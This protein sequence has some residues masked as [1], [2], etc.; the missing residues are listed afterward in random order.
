MSDI[1]G[2]IA[3]GIMAAGSLDIAHKRVRGLWM[4]LLG[5]FGWGYAGYL[6]GLYSLI[7]VSV[8]MGILDVYAIYHWSKD[9]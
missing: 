2:W 9:E 1:V 8:L 6:S 7:G 3:T 5:N 4:M